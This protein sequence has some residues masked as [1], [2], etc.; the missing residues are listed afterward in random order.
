MAGDNTVEALPETDRVVFTWEAEEGAGSYLLVV[1]TDEAMT[2]EAGRL[3]F[4][5]EGNPLK[6][7][8]ATRLSATI[9]GLATGGTYYYRMTALSTEEAV[10]SQYVG[11]F[12]IPTGL[13]AVFDGADEGIECRVEAGVLRIGGAEGETV[14]VTDM[15]GRTLHAAQATDD[16][17]HIPVQ[18]GTYLVRAGR[19]TLKVV[20]D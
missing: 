15:Q 13:E 6:R 1:Y 10:L 17:V 8:A 19:T 5:A 9:E 14:V 4:D 3:R 18:P 12:A 16:E 20:A 7:A 11:S 2:Q